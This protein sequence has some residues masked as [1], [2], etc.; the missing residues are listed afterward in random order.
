VH[1][2][3]A[4]E[5]PVDDNGVRRPGSAKEKVRAR[6]SHFYFSDRI[7]AVTPRELAAAHHDGSTEA[8]ESGQQEQPRAG[9]LVASAHDGDDH[10]GD[11]RP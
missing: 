4:L 10:D 5:A 9:E 1:H 11:G 6:L 3:L 7:E 8:I 2:P